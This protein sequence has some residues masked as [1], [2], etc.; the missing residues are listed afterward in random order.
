M[1]D[2][3]L[4]LRTY[5]ADGSQSL[6]RDVRV[7]CEETLLVGASADEAFLLRVPQATAGRLVAHRF[8]DG[9]ERTLAG[10]DGFDIDLLGRPL[11]LSTD[12][13]RLIA[14]GD[15]CQ[16]EVLDVA[17]GAVS[18]LDLAGVLDDCRRLD[19]LS[20]SPN[21]DRLA[22]TYESDDEL[23]VAVLDLPSGTVLLREVVGT[24]QSYAVSVPPTPFT[25]TAGIAWG[26]DSTLRAAFVRIPPE[27][28]SQVVAAADALDVLA[29]SVP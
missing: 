20:L 24:A 17:S 1:T 28:D 23:T 22:V 7:R 8:S 9:A 29:F 5:E 26:D 6:S 4:Y 27:F 18:P 2:A 15:G 21:G 12:A 13:S 25:Y 11:D 19:R 10:L 3:A 14:V 16:V